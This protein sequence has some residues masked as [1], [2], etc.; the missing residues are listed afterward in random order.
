[1]YEVLRWPGGRF[2]FEAGASLPEAQRAGLGLPSEGV[3]LEGYRRLDEWR[4]IGDYLPGDGSVLARLDSGEAVALSDEERRVLDAV[5]GRRTV[6]EVVDALAMS[7]FDACK[8]LCRLLQARFV[9][10]AA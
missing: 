2:R 6:A 7:S 3:V 4:V 1:V 8:V 9:S 10:L 5:D